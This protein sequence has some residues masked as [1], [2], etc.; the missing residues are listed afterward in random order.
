MPNE[1]AYEWLRLAC[2]FLKTLPDVGESFLELR[3]SGILKLDQLIVKALKCLPC[4]S[5]CFIVHVIKTSFAACI[6]GLCIFAE[7][8]EGT[9]FH[10]ARL[11]ILNLI[12]DWD[13]QG[14]AFKQLYLG[15]LPGNGSG[16]LWLSFQRDRL[17]P[18]RFQTC[19]CHICFI[20]LFVSNLIIIFKVTGTSD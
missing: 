16:Q 4:N 6:F 18:A 3:K 12:I 10:R 17:L 14:N 15:L 2:V 8:T 9:H 20:T 13:D 7:N 5:V 1:R 11:L 19:K